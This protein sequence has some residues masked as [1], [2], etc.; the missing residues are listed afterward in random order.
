MISYKDINTLDISL[1]NGVV[2]YKHEV[3]LMKTPIIIMERNTND[4]DNESDNDNDNDNNN[5]ILLKINKESQLHDKLFTICGY[6]DT[7]YKLKKI[8]SKIINQ[9]KIIINNR[10]D[11]KFFDSNRNCIPFSKV[12]NNVKVIF[13]LGCKD[14]NL[15]VVEGLLYEKME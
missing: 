3:M 5:E 7:L 14:G 9:N 15:N 10:R 13:S 11:T 2:K 12:K 6:I 4:N 1:E 8:N